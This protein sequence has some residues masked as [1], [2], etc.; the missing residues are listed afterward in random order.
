[1]SHKDAQYKPS[2]SPSQ[3]LSINDLCERLGVSRDT[4]YR[5]LVRE[6]PTYRIGERVRFRASDVDAYVERNRETE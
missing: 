2:E 5:R 4:V 3:L 1:M 6:I